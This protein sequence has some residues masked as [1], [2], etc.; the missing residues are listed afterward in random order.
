MKLDDMTE[1]DFEPVH[2]LPAHLPQGERLLWQ[3]APSWRSLAIRAFHVRKVAIYFGLFGLWQIGSA[4]AS[5]QGLPAALASIQAPLLA[6][7]GQSGG[8]CALPAHGDS[9]PASQVT[10]LLSNWAIGMTGSYSSWKGVSAAVASSGGAPAD[11]A[12]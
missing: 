7:A 12:W 4:L 6:A 10:P 9:G 8:S 2:G 5:G 11:L 3:G 1:H